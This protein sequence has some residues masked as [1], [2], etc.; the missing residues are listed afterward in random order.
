M[1]P[2]ATLIWPLLGLAIALNVTAY[3]RRW[4][5]RADQARRRA[6]FL[7]GSLPLAMMALDDRGRVL[8]SNA[9]AR[10]LLGPPRI[11]SLF[12]LSAD[13]KSRSDP[14]ATALA[15]GA[16]CRTTARL[17]RPAGD[18]LDLTVWVAP[19]RGRAGM[20][21]AVA[22]LEPAARPGEE[23]R[24]PG[25]AR[26]GFAAWAE[27][28]FDALPD[29]TLVVDGDGCVTGINRAALDLFG[30]TSAGAAFRPAA[31]YPALLRFRHPAGPPMAG[32]EWLPLR[33]LASADPP[34]G[35]A[36]PSRQTMELSAPGTVSGTRTLSCHAVL[37]TRSDTGERFVLW[38]GRTAAADAPG[39]DQARVGSAAGGRP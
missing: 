32:H 24:G 2:A 8:A 3:L 36:A 13:R 9:A 14:V 31:D 7:L 27:E 37:R 18:W 33:L 6:E 21:A 15:S 19:L 26:M 17:K 28:L 23:G 12:A 10:D 16:P 5:R 22:L 4:A 39:T 25:E 20:P 11:W 1:H 34:R 29:P 35:G 38:V 30:F